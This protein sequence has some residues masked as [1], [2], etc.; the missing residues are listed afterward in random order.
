ME[1]II[2]N[3]SNFINLKNS[4][5]DEVKRIFSDDNSIAKPPNY[6]KLGTLQK[7]DEQ[8]KAIKIMVDTNIPIDN[9][10][11]GVSANKKS[12]RV[13]DFIWILHDLT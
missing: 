7:I 2:S 4:S 1:E 13:H 5:F 9:C 8:S 6:F 3:V 11:D 10:G 12:A